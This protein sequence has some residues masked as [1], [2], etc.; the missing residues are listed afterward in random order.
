MDSLIAEVNAIYAQCGVTPDFDI[1][2]TGI[3]GHALKVRGNWI[4]TQKS[5]WQDRLRRYLLYRKPSLVQEAS[6]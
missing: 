6:T 1:E 2:N 4:S 5:G 3:T